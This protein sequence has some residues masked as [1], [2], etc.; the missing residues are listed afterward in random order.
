M[1][2]RAFVM[3]AVPPATSLTIPLCDPTTFYTRLLRLFRVVRLVTVVVL[4][5]VVFVFVVAVVGACGFLVLPDIL[6]A[7]RLRAA[8]LIAFV[9]RIVVDACGFGAVVVVAD[10]EF[11]FEP[12]FVKISCS[13]CLAVMRLWETVGG[14][15]RAATLVARVGD[16]VVSVTDV[17]VAH[18]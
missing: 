6:N 15:E 16:V 1:N 4:T 9:V 3:Y 18:Y 7:H 13:E 2:A 11:V 14:A 17:A 8:I 10:G 12:R 5:F